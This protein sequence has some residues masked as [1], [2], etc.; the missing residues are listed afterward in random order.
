MILGLSQV[1][2]SYEGLLVPIAI[3]TLTNTIK[4]QAPKIATS[5]D[6]GGK[7]ALDDLQVDVYDT[8]IAIQSICAIYEDK[9]VTAFPKYDSFIVNCFAENRDEAKVWMDQFEKDMRLKNQYR[10]KCLYAEK[11]T[12]FFKDVPKV[13]WDDVILDEKV[14]NDIKLNT[15]DFL[16]NPKFTL[17]GVNK[18]G[19]IMFGPPGTGKTS[20]AKAVFSDLEG[21]DVSRVYVTAESF[22]YMQ[23]NNLFSFLDYLG[24]TVLVFEDVDFMSGNRDNFTSSNQLG[25]LLTNLDGMRKFGDPLVI[26]ASTNKIEMLDGALSSRPCR[27]DRRIEVGLPSPENL[28]AMYFKHL[29][30]DVGDDIL[31]LSK[32]FTGS[33]VVETVN[34]AKIL[35]ANEGKQPIECLKEACEIIRENFFPGQTTVEIKSG[36]KNHFAKKANVKIASKQKNSKV[37]NIAKSILG[38]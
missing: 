12:M 4:Q 25:D 35:A 27:F 2:R 22:K 5:L 1:T 15:S 13:S 29:N 34:T 11:N 38:L 9:I 14:K 32:D 6:F 3:Y 28:K 8:T 7:P 16:S 33:H 26:I 24:P 30:S 18:R 36:I 19:L 21:K 20:I 31:I 37:Q 10:G 17:V 23:V